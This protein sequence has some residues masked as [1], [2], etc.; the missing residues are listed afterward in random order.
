M[1]K[2]F[3][4]IDNFILEEYLI[5]GHYLGCKYCTIYL[6]RHFS[7]FIC[8]L[9]Y[10]CFLDYGLRALRYEAVQLLLIYARFDNIETFKLNDDT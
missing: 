6:H 4:K 5:S 8:D 7:V 9:A 1:M 2:Y 3:V 10:K